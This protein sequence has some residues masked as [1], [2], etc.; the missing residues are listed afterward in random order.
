MSIGVTVII[1]E[2]SSPRESEIGAVKS[3]AGLVEMTSVD[4]AVIVAL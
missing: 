4:L 1:I 3:R 2:S